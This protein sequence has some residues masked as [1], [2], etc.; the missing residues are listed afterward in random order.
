MADLDRARRA[1]AEEGLGGWLF[2][3]QYHKDPIADRVLDIASERHNT[4]PWLYLL[5]PQ[6]DPLKLVH[7]I[8]ATLLDHLPGEKRVYASHDRF[9]ASLREL[10]GTVAAD[11]GGRRP[12]GCQFSE[13]L[14]ALSYLDHGMARLLEQCGFRL[15]SSAGLVQR[16]L[17]VLSPEG[18]ASHERA[19]AKLYQI[20]AE[21]WDR[22]GRVLREGRQVV[23]GEVQ[24]WMLS[25]FAEKGLVT[26]SPPIVA[27][28]RHSA[29]PHYEPQQGGGMLEPEA[30]LQLD[31]WAREP[32]PGAVFA[33]ISWVGVL[34]PSA[35]EEVR[36]AFAA[37]REARELAVRLIAE[38]F[39][40]GRPPEGREVDQ[41]V[42]SFLSQ[43]GYGEHL[44]H[45]TGH[46]IDER[47]H[48]FGANLDSVEF[49]DPRRLLEGACFSVE[50][51]VYRPGFGVRTE[52]DVY[53]AGLRPVVSG[54]TPQ[55]E[56]LT[57]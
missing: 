49:P 47:V 48:G 9:V 41:A 43:A 10:A 5:P 26:D 56:L 32:A 50:P 17:G 2:C 51:G 28:G 33:D 46:A 12:V 30:V 42:R 25:L 14:P 44:R 45:R 27:A 38:R 34:G 36:R 7:T 40:A 23:E 54:G 22:L 52:I 21:I 4:R 18:I 55:G 11:A 8:E 13:E 1:V 35:S 39:A 6:G 31:L 37:V 29:D 57:F 15:C 53:I 20:V 16:S 24:A 19:A 3:N